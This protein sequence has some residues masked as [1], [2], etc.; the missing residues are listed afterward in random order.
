MDLFV[1]DVVLQSLVRVSTDKIYVIILFE[2][3]DKL[4]NK[5]AIADGLEDFQL[6]HRQFCEGIRNGPPWHLLHFK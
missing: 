4:D 5:L 1:G 6:V 2:V 3:V